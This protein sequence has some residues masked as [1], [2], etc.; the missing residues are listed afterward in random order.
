MRDVSGIFRDELKQINNNILIGK[1]C[2]ESDEAYN[3]IPDGFS[4]LH[5][6]RAKPNLCLPT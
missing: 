2:S 6:D 4:F 5:I 3:W 1:Y